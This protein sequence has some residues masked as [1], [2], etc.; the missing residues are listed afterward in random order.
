[1]WTR[2]S[3]STVFLLP[4]KRVIHFSVV[5]SSVADAWCPV[6]ETVHTDSLRGW[7]VRSS[8]GCNGLRNTREWNCAARPTGWALGPLDLGEELTAQRVRLFI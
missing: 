8:R 3:A 5:R 1:M 4:K 7:Q 6:R 2:V